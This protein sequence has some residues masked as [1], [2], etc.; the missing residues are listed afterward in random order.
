[1]LCEQGAVATGLL[2]LSRSLEIA[3]RADDDGLR[4]AARANLAHWSGRLHTLRACLAHPDPVA[5]V[6]VSPDGAM[7]ATGC[8]DALVRFWDAATGEMTG[9]P[10]TLGGPV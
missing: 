2:W 10:L 8:D 3:D 5:A 7:V 1:S 9:A 6:A 4:R